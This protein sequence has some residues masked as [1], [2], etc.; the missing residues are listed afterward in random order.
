MTPKWYE[1]TRRSKVSV[2]S[3]TE[4]IQSAKRKLILPLEGRKACHMKKPRSQKVVTYANACG[5]DSED[6]WTLVNRRRKLRSRNVS[7]PA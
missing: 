3:Q 2:A 6:E 7:M 5:K 4:A 1:E